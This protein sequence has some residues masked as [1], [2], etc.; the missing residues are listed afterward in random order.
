MY[1]SEP[2]TDFRSRLYTDDGQGIVVDFNVRASV[3][4]LKIPDGISRETVHALVG[5][6]HDQFYRGDAD[7]LSAWRQVVEASSDER[8]QYLVLKA[9]D[10]LGHDTS[11]A[12]LDKGEPS[13]SLRHWRARGRTER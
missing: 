2:L 13:A 7:R 12:L 1:F 10:P 4:R 9:I 8:P 11:G 6:L 3:W 5:H